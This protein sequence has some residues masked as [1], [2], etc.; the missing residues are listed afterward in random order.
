MLSGG[1]ASPADP[2]H[3]TQYSIDE[4][5]AAVEEAEAAGLYVMAHAY[6]ARAVNRALRGGVRSIE[7]GTLIDQESIG[8]F[9]HHDAFLV[10]TIAVGRLIRTVGLNLGFGQEHF[11][12]MEELEK[13]GQQMLAEADRAGLRIA[14]GTD[15]NGDL[16]RYQSMEFS[17]RGEIQAPADVIRSATCVAAEL[18]QMRGK[19]GVVA[20][21]A[22]ADL[23]IVDGNPLKD[24]K[25]LQDE[26]RHLKMIM[27]GGTLFK[28][29]LS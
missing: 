6:T 24:L 29:E 25:V 20:E 27:K 3:F 12:R 10:P 7:H 14:F 28:N 26:G 5:R 1:A 17:I 21:G 19:I 16:H 23:L 8:L 9:K 4:I 18:F 13:K 15:L 11:R 22:R 2:I